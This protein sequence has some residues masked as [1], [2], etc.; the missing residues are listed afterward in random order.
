MINNLLFNERLKDGNKNF[1]QT[2]LN[3]Y[4]QTNLKISIPSCVQNLL[5][6]SDT[7]QKKL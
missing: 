2:N 3:F 5:D 6:A 1:H 4:Y 7:C